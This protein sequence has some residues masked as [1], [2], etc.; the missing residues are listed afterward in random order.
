MLNTV[1]FTNSVGGW[2]DSAKLGN[3][4]KVAILHCHVPMSQSRFGFGKFLS[5]FIQ[6]FP[7][8][9]VHVGMILGPVLRHNARRVPLQMILRCARLANCLSLEKTRRHW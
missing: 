7:S 6:T 1:S 4:G 3:V 2:E 5:K 9:Y 8:N